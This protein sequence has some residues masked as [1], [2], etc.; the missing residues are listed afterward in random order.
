MGDLQQRKINTGDVFGVFPHLANSSSDYSNRK[1]K[2]R[3]E[4][5]ETA[6]HHHTLIR[7][8][9]KDNQ[10]HEWGELCMPRTLSTGD[11]E[12]GGHTGT[13]WKFPIKLRADSSHGPELHA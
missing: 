5:R 11:A 2:Q 7:T 1:I 10:Q 12:C 6:R 3:E 4:G 9:L 13:V 8:A